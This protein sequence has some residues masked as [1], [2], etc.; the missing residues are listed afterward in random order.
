MRD[1][2]LFI[3]MFTG[4]WCFVGLIFLIIG[5]AFKRS[6]AR[7]EERLRA[8]AEGTVTE[9]V[10]RKSKDTSYFYP[11]VSFDYEGRTISLESDV[12]GGRKK[13]Y[14]GQ[15]VGVLYDP[16]DPTVFRLGS[17]NGTR[18]IGRILLAVGLACIAVGII[19]G[20]LA[21]GIPFKFM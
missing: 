4:I 3:I 2:T 19:A 7:R 17:D 18:L 1:T 15:K 9:I 6:F 8:Y 16:D 21:S 20:L 10:R 13:Y 14:E 11:I 5:I 12:G